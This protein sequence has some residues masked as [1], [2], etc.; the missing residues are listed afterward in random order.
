MSK[1]SKMGIC[2]A[3]GC[4]FNKLSEFDDQNGQNFLNKV[5]RFN[6]VHIDNYYQLGKANLCS[7]KGNNSI[8]L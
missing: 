6:K 2:A 3:K 5:V 1:M 4:S 7:L 8:I